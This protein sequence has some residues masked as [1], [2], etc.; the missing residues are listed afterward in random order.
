L[1]Q[2]LQAGSRTLYG[3]FAFSPDGSLLALRSYEATSR[4][5]TIQIYAVTSGKLRRHLPLALQE[6]PV[7]FSPDGRT[8]A[9]ADGVGR[10]QLWEVASG[11]E[12]GRLGQDEGPVGAIAFSPDGRRMCSASADTTALVWDLAT[13]FRDGPAR[14]E[15]S[16]IECKELWTCLAADDARK[17]YRA[18]WTLVVSPHQSA[19]LLKNHL[20]A[21][22]APDPAYVSGLLA[23]LDHKRFAARQKAALEL[24][25][26]GQ[27]VEPDL[28]KALER[29]PSLEVR[30]RL[31][32]LLE[33]AA[34]AFPDR[35]TLQTLRAVEVLE[36]MG[37]SAAVQV[38]QTVASGAPEAPQTQSAQASL[39]RL[40]GR[41]SGTD[42]RGR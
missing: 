3:P 1:L 5:S 23:D 31:E 39:N 18:H 14:T 25:K 21:V 38:L 6:R 20:R 28:R 9:S 13:M 11:A 4:E 17:A 33:K 15:L 40:A 2:T 29:P 34:E 10:I 36:Q 16:A 8:L 24:E 12:R 7:G 22:K 41:P 19:P 26:L 27:L 32:Q 37:S 42:Q 35:A 30:R